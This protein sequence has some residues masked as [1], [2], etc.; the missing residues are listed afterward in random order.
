MKAVHS[1]HS[2]VSRILLTSVNAGL[3]T[4]DLLNLFLRSEESWETCGLVEIWFPV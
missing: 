3:R 2:N 1:T 4:D